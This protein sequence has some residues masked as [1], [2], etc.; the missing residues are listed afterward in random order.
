MNE[1]SENRPYHEL[2]EFDTKLRH[3]LSD[4]WEYPYLISHEPWF[5]EPRP[6]PVGPGTFPLDLGVYGAIK[7]IE[8]K[9]RFKTGTEAQIQAAEEGAPR[10]NISAPE[11]E[12]IIPVGDVRQW[13]IHLPAGTQ[14]HA[15]IDKWQKDLE[16]IARFPYPVM[17]PER[18][19]R[20]RKALEEARKRSEQ[21]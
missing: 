17:T 5:R 6:L 2:P 10:Y 16:K 9:Y 8:V 18:L 1:K 13:V 21:G 15:Y 14:V 3:H 11:G 20:G 4:G 7:T 19:E 12:V